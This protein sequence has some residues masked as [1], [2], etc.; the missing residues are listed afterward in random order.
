MRGAP[1]AAMVGINGALSLLIG[2]LILVD[3]PSSAD[4]AIG[5]LVGI[6]LLFAGWS[7]VSVS[8]LGR[9]LVA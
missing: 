1:N 2:L 4:W 3:F 7:L 8:S 5:L 6:D 9:R